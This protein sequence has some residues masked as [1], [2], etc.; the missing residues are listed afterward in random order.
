[1]QHDHHAL[2]DVLIHRCLRRTPFSME[3]QEYQRY[4]ELMKR[5]DAQL[6]LVCFLVA[7]GYSSLYLQIIGHQH[8]LWLMPRRAWNRIEESYVSWAASES[9]VTFMDDHDRRGRGNSE[10]DRLNEIMTRF[11]RKAATKATAAACPICTICLESVRVRQ[12][13]RELC[14]QSCVFHKRCIDRWLLGN[15]TCPTCRRLSIIDT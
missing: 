10:A 4:S 3:N 2:L 12:H 15:R 9:N 11:P 13:V 8:D 1:M 7:N 14:G 6:D 5:R